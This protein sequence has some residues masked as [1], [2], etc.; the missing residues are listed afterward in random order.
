[1]VDLDFFAN[2]K[3]NCTNM[4][5]FQS[6]LN[7][8]SDAYPPIVEDNKLDGLSLFEILLEYEKVDL[9]R[10]QLL[11]AVKK[12]RFPDL[13]YNFKDD[14]NTIQRKLDEIDE[15]RI[16]YLCTQD[17]PAYSPTTPPYSPTS[18]AYSPTSPP[19]SPTSPAYS[20]T[21]PPYSPTSPAYSTPS[22]YIPYSPTS[23][24]YK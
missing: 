14:Y 23:P 22:S 15:L 6:F 20:P 7:E 24:P 1:M 19:Y 11:W 5:N 2:N 13:L 16:D 9:R 12:K 8:A 18:P 21:S 3:V 10:S 17:S 4:A